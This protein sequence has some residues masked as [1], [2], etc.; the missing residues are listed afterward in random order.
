ML[1][2]IDI[3][4][5]RRKL[6]NDEIISTDEVSDL[7][8]ELAHF[9]KAASYLASCQAATLEGLPKSAPKSQRGRHVTICAIAGQLLDEDASGIGYQ[10]DLQHA[11][12]RCVKAVESVAN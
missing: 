11:R 2:M 6:V 8:S 9:R 3:Q 10:I 1:A 7:L 4:A 12:D 5:Y